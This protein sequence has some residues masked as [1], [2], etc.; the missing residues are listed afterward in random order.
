LEHKK[1]KSGINSIEGMDIL[2]ALLMDEYLHKIEYY[3]YDIQLTYYHDAIFD[4]VFVN[5][6][7]VAQFF[8][9]P[10]YMRSI[11]AAYILGVSDGKA[12]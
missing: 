1:E 10:E 8:A 12:P 6:N 11:P 3:T 2:G 9:Y 4:M 5:Y 7:A